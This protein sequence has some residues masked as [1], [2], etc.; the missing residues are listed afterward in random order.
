MAWLR[1]GG[2]RCDLEAT[3]GARCLAGTET[4][5]WLG[6]L[7]FGDLPQ[8]QNP[9]AGR[10]VNAN[11]RIVDT[12]YPHLIAAYWQRPHRAQRINDL[13]DGLG[14]AESPHMQA[15]QQD[16]LSLAARQLLSELLP[17]IEDAP[18][19]ASAAKAIMTAWDGTMRRSDAAP[20]VFHAWMWALNQALIA[21]ELGPD[22]PSFQRPTADLLHGILTHGQAWCDDIATPQPES[23]KE[24][25]V[26]ALSV[27]WLSLQ[28]RFGDDPAA[29]RWGKAHVARFPHPL[30][31]RV[32]IL[33]KL[34]EPSVE[35]DGG[36]YTI[37]R[38]GLRFGG[39][40]AGRFAHIHGAGYRGIYDL[41][42]LEQSLFIIAPGQ[43][44]NPL[45]PHYNDLAKAWRDGAYLSWPVSGTQ[46]VDRLRLLPLADKN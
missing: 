41:A 31:S 16:S 9:P 13:L 5:D 44:G 2:C 8:G 43:S 11:N 15:I 23:C 28:Q 36:H 19:P 33:N 39:D 12:D 37:N 45:S 22:F 20:L 7:P 32:P 3:A 34:F 25:V 18:A 24:Q 38:G 40:E 14:P 17:L 6:F 26:E 21:D 27:A 42:D 4:H 29:W 46:G 1:P 35:T 30:L 10:L